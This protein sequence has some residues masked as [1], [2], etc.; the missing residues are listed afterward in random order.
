M[1][2]KDDKEA[3][4][5]GFE[6]PRSPGEGTPAEE[7]SHPEQTFEPPDTAASAAEA[8]QMQM[9]A[10]QAE[11]GGDL[12]ALKEE[13][14]KK[15]S[16]DA[17]A[18]GAR[19]QELGGSNIVG[20]GFGFADP[21]AM[22]VGLG[23]NVVPGQLALNVY[24]VEAVPMTQL[25]AEISSAAGTRALSE[26]PVNQ[27]PCG[28]IEAYPH[29]MR[30][31][32][33]PGGISVAHYAVTA[34]TIASLTVGLTPPRTN[35]L[36][37][38]SNNHV[39]ANSN[40]G[41]YGHCICQPGPADGG[42]CPGDQIAILERF[43]PINFAGGINFVDCA[44]GWCWPDRVR[45]ELMYLWAGTPAYYRVASIPVAPFVGMI[46]GKSGRTTQ[47]TQGR[48]TGINVTVNVNYGVGVAQ[49]RDQI[50]FVGNGV[51]FSL[52][53]DSGSL[54]WHWSTTLSPV[55]LLFAGGGATTFG[56]RITRVLTALDV[57]LYT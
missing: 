11:V 53:G 54:I 43:V 41:S 17:S 39:L 14:E 36:L 5:S 24:T 56:N 45:R 34:G 44:T 37:V 32:P 47:L 51:Q 42:Q 15:L 6:A 31:R 21:V 22:G 55:A 7:T 8:D 27:I 48:V 19:A 28:V 20:V 23:S 50:S 16:A 29:R 2:K 26:A 35:R 12:V 33:A 18:A 1:P 9:L 13:L 10:A 40:R 4:S 52:P 3:R 25:M 49:F 57:R 30:L 46:V 38:L